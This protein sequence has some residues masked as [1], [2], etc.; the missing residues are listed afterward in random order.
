MSF[1]KFPN[2]D[3]HQET[4]L[5]QEGENLVCDMDIGWQLFRDNQYKIDNGRGLSVNKHCLGALRCEEYK[6]T[7]RPASNEHA[8]ESKAIGGCKTKKCWSPNALTIIGCSV[9]VNIKLLQGKGFLKHT[10]THTHDQ[11]EPLHCTIKGLQ[12]L[13]PHIQEFIGKTPKGLQVR[14][15]A[16]RLQHPPRPVCELDQNLQHLGKVGYARRVIFKN[17]GIRISKKTGASVEGLLDNL[18]TL[19]ESYPGYF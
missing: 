19:E 1:T 8:T 4:T 2:G 9:M 11:F 14:T 5:L 16:V 12:A 7:F 3:Y 6:T 15:S 13:V 10:G 17:H 18:K